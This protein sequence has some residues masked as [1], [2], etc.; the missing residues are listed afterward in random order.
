MTFT[1]LKS[2]EK[3]KP[4]CVFIKKCLMSSIHFYIQSIVVGSGFDQ[5]YKKT[6][7]HS[8]SIIFVL[9]FVDMLFTVVLTSVCVCRV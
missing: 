1:I 7:I 6:P 8:I 2:I 4:Y 3:C 5:I 9:L